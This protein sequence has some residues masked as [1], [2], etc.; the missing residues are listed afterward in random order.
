MP[1]L[2]IFFILTFVGLAKFLY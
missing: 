1:R 2:D